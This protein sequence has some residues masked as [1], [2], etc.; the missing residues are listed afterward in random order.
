[1]SRDYL[2]SLFEFLESNGIA[3]AAEIK[4]VC[5]I[6]GYNE[7]SMKDILWC[8]E[9]YRSFEQIWDCCREDYDFSAIKI[10]MED[11]EDEEEDEEEN[12]EE[13]EEDQGKEKDNG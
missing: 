7:K 9:G 3:T 8:R 10:W 1:M 11:E 12:E 5:N 6:N 13:N 2:D 4:L